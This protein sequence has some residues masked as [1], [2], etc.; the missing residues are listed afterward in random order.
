MKDVVLD[1]SQM[2][3]VETTHDYLKMQLNLPAHY[4]R[5][6]DALWD[7]LSTYNQP[8]SMHI[9]SCDALEKELG[10]YGLKLMALFEEIGMYNKAIMVKF[11][12]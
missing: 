5:N 1:G 8:L 9:T 12:R 3:T 10:D 7:E 11:E 6:L 2:K 4:G